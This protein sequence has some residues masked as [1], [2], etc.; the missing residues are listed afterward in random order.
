[1]I[2]PKMEWWAYFVALQIVVLLPLSIAVVFAA[3]ALWL[4]RMWWL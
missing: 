3:P 1:M 2:I 4:L